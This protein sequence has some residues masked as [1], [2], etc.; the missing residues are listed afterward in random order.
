MKYIIFTI[1]LVLGVPVMAGASAF[2]KKI[3]HLLLSLLVISFLF[4]TKFSINILSMEYYRGPVRGYEISLSDLIC[5]G[6]I[7][8]MLLRTGNK[9][10]WLPRFTGVFSLFFLYAVFSVYRSNYEI[11]G[12]FVIWQLFRMGV[13]YW[14]VVNFFATEEYSHESIVAIMRGYTIT[15]LILLVISFKQKYLDGAYRT[16]AFFDHS[17]TIP[18]FAL[19]LLCVLLIWGLREEKLLGFQHLITLVAVLGLVF[20]VFSTSSRTGMVTAAGSVVCALIITNFR[21]SNKRAHRATLLIGVCMLIGSLMILDTFIYRFLYAPKESEEARNEFEI[22]AIMMADDHQFGVGLNQ[23]SQVL[24]MEE[25][26]RKHIKVM[27]NEEQGG[28]AHHIYL[29]TAAEM[30]YIG[31]YA[32]IFILGLLLLSMIL[33]GITMKT[34]E[35]RLL[36]GL[37]VGFLVLYAIG[38]Y[39]WVLR[40][41]PVLY[42][43]VVAAGFGQALINRVIQQRKQKDKCESTEITSERCPE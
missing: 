4:G 36:L 11:Y 1:A 10:I 17:N 7:I 28:V 23:Y 25:E 34:I 3:K 29:L 41:S 43:F 16:W 15:G 26:Y 24:T 20:A 2:S 40:Q 38:L 9:I 32:F 31:L 27:K 42:Q 18:S 39:E 33:F 6:L 37:A 30:G 12:W 5:L 13:L 35:Q 22:A 19:I 8:G 14:C 21:G